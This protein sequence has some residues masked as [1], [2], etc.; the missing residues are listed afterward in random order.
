MDDAVLEVPVSKKSPKTPVQWDPV[1][2]YNTMTVEKLKKFAFVDF[3]K[4]MN[5]L[6]NEWIDG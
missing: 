4:F 3:S 2:E 1:T 5:L 6:K